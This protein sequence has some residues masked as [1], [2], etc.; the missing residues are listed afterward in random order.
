MHD[1]SFVRGTIVEST[2]ERVVIQ[3]ATG[4]VRTIERSS[5]AEVR[6]SDAPTVTPTPTPSAPIPTEPHAASST[7]DGRRVV[8]RLRLG[9]FLFGR[10]VAETDSAVT[11]TL[12]DG[13]TRIVPRSDIAAI[14]TTGEETTGGPPTARPEVRRSGSSGPETT[15]DGSGVLHVTADEEAVSLYRLSGSSRVPALVGNVQTTALVDQFSV[16]CN[17]PCDVEVPHGAY[18]LGVARGD[19]RA[20]RVGRPV[21]VSRSMSI[22][23]EIDS[24]EL[25]Q[26]V[27]VLVLFGPGLAG[28]VT[29]FAGVFVGLDT[30]RGMR[31]CNSLET[32]VPFIAGGGVVL[33]LALAVGIPLAALQDHVALRW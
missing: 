24:R 14:R 20:S 25:E 18:Q 17:V 21:T 11:L 7:G 4:E 23:I 28:F 3:L 6:S 9:E 27:G 29:V 8:V 10:L 30:C 15:S 33:A 19:S 26:V 16:L 12:D 22:H 32:A 1:G 2:P 31:D 13:A 5:V